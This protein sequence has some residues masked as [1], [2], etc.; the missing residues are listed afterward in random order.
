MIDINDL[1]KE[2]ENIHESKGMVEDIKILYKYAIEN[3]YKNILELGI[4][5]GNSTKTFA[6]AASKIPGCLFTSVDIE[7]YCI[8]EMKQK[9]KVYGLEKYVNFVNS[10]SVKFMESQPDKTYDCIFID[11]SH[12]L[13]QTIAELFVAALKVQPGGHIFMHDTAMP[14]ICR[15]IEIFKQYT[16]LDFWN[17]STPAGLGLIEMKK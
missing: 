11:T 12:S 7:E 8:E 4:L 2:F 3:Q 10:D 5:H 15:A 6:L 13:N 9:L 1:I 14:E 17:F 16:K